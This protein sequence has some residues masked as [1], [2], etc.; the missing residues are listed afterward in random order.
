[1]KNVLA[2]RPM[3][4][5]VHAF[6]RIKQHRKKREKITAKSNI[7]IQPSLHHTIDLYKNNV[8]MQSYTLSAGNTGYIIAPYIFGLRIV[9]Q[10]NVQATA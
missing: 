5:E 2:Y 3:T 4:E 8:T 9:R 1:M 6:I 7:R 10:Y